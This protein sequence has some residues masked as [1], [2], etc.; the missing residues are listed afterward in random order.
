MRTFLGNALQD[1]SQTHLDAASTFPWR[2][3]L[4]SPMLDS[5]D[6]VDPAMKPRQLI[7]TDKTLQDQPRW[8]RD[9]RSICEGN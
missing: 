7:L 9:D 2:I 5:K 3:F 1:D 4:D 6:M 8:E